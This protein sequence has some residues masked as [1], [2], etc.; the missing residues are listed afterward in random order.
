LNQGYP[1]DYTRK[2]EGLR[3]PVDTIIQAAAG[4]SIDWSHFDVCSYRNNLNKI[5]LTPIS[6][7]DGWEMDC[8]FH[9][10]SGT[11]FLDIVPGPQATWKDA[12]KF[13]F[14][15]YKFEAVCTGRQATCTAHTK[16][17][18]SLLLETTSGMTV[19]QHWQLQQCM[20]Q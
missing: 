15:G 10:K 8:C 11:L 12:D 1:Q 19:N 2:Q 14:Y 18:L 4:Q 13:T 5:L 6:P 17:I 20:W 9:E 3:S 16:C 7:R